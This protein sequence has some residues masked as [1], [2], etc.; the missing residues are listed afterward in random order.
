MKKMFIIL[1]FIIISIN[2]CS[3]ID[4]AVY[5]AD[6]YVENKADDYFDLTRDQSKWL[7]SSLKSD[8]A[9]IKKT[10]FP[11]L[12]AELLRAADAIESQRVFET[13]TVQLSFDR[14]KNLF[15]DGLRTFSP[16]AIL[17]ADQLAPSQ[18]NVFQ[19]EFDKKMRDLKEDDNEIETFKK[20]RKHFESWMGNLNSEQKKEL[21]KFVKNTSSS[22]NEKIYNRQVLAHEFVRVYPDRG[23]RAKFVEGLFTRYESMREPGYSKFMAQKDKQLIALITNI[24]NKMSESQRETLLETLRERANQLTKLSKQ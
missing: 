16:E 9:K 23:A 15:Y 4:L 2:A 3:R 7:K 18:I 6:T 1:S 11:Q 10:I 8:I 19:K 5:F 24:L 21:E 12:A 17:F 13:S 22:I 20:M 14:A